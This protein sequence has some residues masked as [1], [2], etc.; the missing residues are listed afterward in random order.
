MD[1]VTNHSMNYS[2][3]HNLV[4]VTLFA[5]IVAAFMDHSTPTAQN[6]PGDYAATVQVPAIDS[7]A[8]PDAMPR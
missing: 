3:L 6:D 1:P 5:G 2:I 4:A 7:V 8:S